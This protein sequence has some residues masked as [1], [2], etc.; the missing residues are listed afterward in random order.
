MASKN[1]FV[2]NEACGK[3][4]AYQIFI[5]TF[6]L[7]TFDPRK[8]G[9]SVVYLGKTSL[10]VL[11]ILYFSKMLSDQH[12][13]RKCLCC[14]MMLIT[15]MFSHHHRSRSIHKLVF[16]R[17]WSK[18]SFMRNTKSWW[19]K[20]LGRVQDWSVSKMPA[21]WNDLLS[22]SFLQVAQ[23]RAR[24]TPDVNKWNSLW[25]ISAC[26]SICYWS[27]MSCW[28]FNFKQ[29]WEHFDLNFHVLYKFN[30]ILHCLYN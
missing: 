28:D 6:V 14:R 17:G 8:A 9:K 13:K 20:Q 26:V 18:H 16:W 7:P 22:S 2:T 15:S 30:L 25:R 29:L 24:N 3:R 23:I 21:G 11:N 19:E 1:T 10:K 27:L 5:Q 12:R 4:C